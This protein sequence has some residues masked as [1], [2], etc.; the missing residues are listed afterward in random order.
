MSVFLFYEFS[1]SIE[2]PFIQCTYSR[3]REGAVQ[4]LFYSILRFSDL[5][6]QVDAEQYTPNFHNFASML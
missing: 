1:D 2:A 5:L 6:V 4:V 3:A